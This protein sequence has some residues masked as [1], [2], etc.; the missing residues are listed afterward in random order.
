MGAGRTNALLVRYVVA[1]LL[2]VVAEWAVFIA[3]LVYV[4][5][6]DGSGAMG[7]AAIVML[8]PYVVVSPFAGQLAER[9]RPSRVRLAGLAGQTAGYGIAAITAYQGAPTW[10]TIGGAV[11]ALGSVTTL[12]PAGAVLLPALVHSSRQL[13][14]ANLWVGHTES[15]SV[16]VGPIVTT[17]LLAVDGAAFALAGTAFIAG[18]ALVIAAI[19]ATVDPPAGQGGTGVIHHATAALRAITSRPGGTGVLAIAVVQ[20]VLVGALDLIVV[21]SAEDVLDMGETGVGV[22]STLFGVGAL[23]STV[24]AAVL[25]QRRRLAPSLLV[26][27]LTMAAMCVLFGVRLTLVTALIALPVLGVS[28]SVLDLLSRML[29]QRSAP[30]SELGGVFALVE[31][32]SGLGLITGSVLAQVLIAVDGPGAA[33]IGVAA[34]F[35]VVLALV[36]PALRTADAGADVPVVAMSL[37]RLDPVFAPL[38]AL[39]LEAVARSATEVEVPAGDEVIRQG[40]P[41]DT[42]FVVA[43]GS[44]DVSMDGQ[45]VRTASRGG[46]FGEVALLADIPRTGSVTA[47]T[48]GVLLAIDRVPFLVAVTGHDSSRQAAW[49]VIRTMDLG[50]ELAE[51]VPVDTD[52]ANASSGDAGGEEPGG[53]RPTAP[54]GDR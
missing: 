47:A 36:V 2:A 3:L 46:S 54:L 38:P 19:G 35:V 44:F 34:V 27:L 18:A 12:R 21:V 22:L 14:T 20:Y 13:T 39:E 37:L 29:L 1:H 51:P 26:A 30:P 11:L 52:A 4:H 17:G 16:L 32:G 53:D 24:L 40:E 15:A 5:D 6:R 41:G 48:D 45:H 28:R 33:L 23:A 43:S 8:L 10:T 31:V 9:H 25:V 42:Y 49:G 50:I 7:V